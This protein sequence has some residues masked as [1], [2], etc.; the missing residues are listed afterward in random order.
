MKQRVLIV[1]DHKMFREALKYI[2]GGTPDIEV[3][4]EAGDGT[5]ALAR[6]G[7]THPD[8]VCM[9]VNMPGP[10]G[11]ET[12]RQLLAAQPGVKVI[13][14]SAYSGKEYVLG[15]LDAGAVG[16]VTKD[17]AGNELLQAIRSVALG[18]TYLCPEAA[19]AA[20][21]FVPA[22]GSKAVF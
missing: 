6:A 22:K 13:G 14:L 2:L 11:I 19:A 5:E 16:Y 15:M 18:Q 3:V 7:E 4:A 10:N 1:D 20:A 9:D 8:I 17:E 21:E 12:T